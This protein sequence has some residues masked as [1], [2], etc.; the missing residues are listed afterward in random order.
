MADDFGKISVFPPPNL[1]RIEGDK[2]RLLLVE[3]NYKCD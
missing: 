1:R 3:Y 2:K